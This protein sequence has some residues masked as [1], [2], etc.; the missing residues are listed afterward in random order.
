M[1][2]IIFELSFIEQPIFINLLAS[3]TFF[4]I[5]ELSIIS[6]STW[7]FYHTNSMS[8]TISKLTIIMITI[9]PVVISDAIWQILLKQSSIGLS[10]FKSHRPVAPFHEMLELSLI[11]CIVLSKNTK[12]IN[13]IWMPFANIRKTWFSFPNTTTFLFT[14]FPLTIILLSITPLKS[15]FS[16]PPSFYEVTQIIWFIRII[17]ISQTLFAAVDKMA[18]KSL[19]IF[20]KYDPS[21]LKDL[22]VSP[23]LSKIDSW[24]YLPEKEMVN[25]YI[26]KSL[27]MRC[28]LLSNWLRIK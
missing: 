26:S 17:F 20:I 21:T 14:I 5:L 15:T 12:A 19:T 24:F 4:I 10:I 18:F 7:I 11:S 3:S 16:F 22:C 2:Q 9:A 6:T 13:C 23:Q 25:L 27:K 28:I 1:P 8:F